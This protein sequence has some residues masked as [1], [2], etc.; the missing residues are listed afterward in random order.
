MISPTDA[1]RTARR[2]RVNRYENVTVGDLVQS[3]TSE[4]PVIGFVAFHI[5]VAVGAATQVLTTVE[6]C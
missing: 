3:G 4:P 5:D 1:I 6:E 2:T